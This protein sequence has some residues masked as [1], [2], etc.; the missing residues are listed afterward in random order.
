ML[1]RNGQR[2]VSNDSTEA[3]A[4]QLPYEQACRAYC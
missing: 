3:L 1:S 4:K 2:R